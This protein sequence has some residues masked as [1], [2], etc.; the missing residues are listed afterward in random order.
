MN[1][2]K[3]TSTKANRTKI[4]VLDFTET[5]EMGELCST[6][7]EEKVSNGDLID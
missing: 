6:D 2:H 5:D 1:V 4:N 7:S 3:G